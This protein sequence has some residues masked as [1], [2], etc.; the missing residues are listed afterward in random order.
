MP[1]RSSAGILVGAFGCTKT[2]VV[3]LHERTNRTISKVWAVEKMPLVMRTDLS[4]NR[5]GFL[6]TG[7]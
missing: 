5:T 7:L 6:E 3:V 4:S 1:F 2:V